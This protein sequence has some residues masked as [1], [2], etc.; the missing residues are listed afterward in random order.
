VSLLFGQQARTSWPP[1]ILVPARG[2]TMN[3]GGIV[4]VTADTALRH[5]AVWACIKLQADLMSSFPIDVL[6]DVDIDGA[7]TMM[8]AETPTPMV[9]KQPGGASCGINEWMFSTQADKAASGNTFGVI[10]KRDGFG[11]PACIEL[12]DRST[13]VVVVRANQLRGYR[14]AGKWYDPVDVWHEKSNTRSGMFV[15]LSPIAYAAWSISEYLSAQEFAIQWFG[16]GA[17]PSG[18]L[19]NSAKTLSP[20]EA[21]TTK[22]KWRQAVA[23][24]DVFVTGADWDYS[25]MTGENS[26]SALLETKRYS[27]SDI[28][29]FFGV[30][31]D[32]IDAAESLG[33]GKI[34]YANITQRNLEY[35]ILHLGPEITRRE[36]ALTTLVPSQRYVK[37]NT[38][39]LLRMD[40]AA[41]A[42]LFQT[43]INSRTLAPSE[44]RRYENQAPFTQAQIDEFTTL[45]GPPGKATT[46][47][48]ES[49]PA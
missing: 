45:F 39:S 20:A 25:M 24:R 14:I 7:G 13:V 15:G 42:A 34:T 12:Q 2:G 17:I 43:R 21:E 19:K 49:V 5:S 32:L 1:E 22:A 40:P 46:T 37:L 28:G 16:T 33:G 23:N 11:L 44:A 48:K 18:V 6:R 27:I 31:G 8:P 26:T 30:P 10:T 9:L 47:P 41:R 35:L 29:R 3:R 4:N 38:D 36:A